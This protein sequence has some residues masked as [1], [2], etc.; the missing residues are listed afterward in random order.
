VTTLEDMGRWLEVHINGGRLDGKQILPEAAVAEAHRNL[1]PF[2]G[3]QRGLRQVGY[4]LGWQ[5]SMFGGGGGDTLL[6]HG[7]GFP[8][9]ATHMSFMPQQRIGVAVFS[10]TGLGGVVGDN[11]AF[12][13]YNALTSRPT[14]S[15]DSLGKLRT[16]VAARRAAVDKD[17]ATRAARRQTLPLPLDAYA[18]TYV[19]PLM[20]RVELR[21]TPANKLEARMGV[22]SSAVEAFDAAKHRLRVE[23]FGA[24]MVVQMFVSRGRADSLTMDGLVYRR[25]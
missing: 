2:T 11:I 6:I 17:L 12:Q 5:L 23:L 15:A 3:N 16:L 25:R 10:N 18:G 14:L 22:A 20:G 1:A 9:F 8:G 21:T 7:G 13:I 19:N 4:G 24:G